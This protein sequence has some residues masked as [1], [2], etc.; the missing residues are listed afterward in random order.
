MKNAIVGLH[1]VGLP[2]RP[3]QWDA[4]RIYWQ[5][6]GMDVWEITVDDPDYDMH[7]VGPRLQ[8]GKRPALMISYFIG[9]GPGHVALELAPQAL[10]LAR[11]IPQEMS[12]THWGHSVTSLFLVTPHTSPVHP[13][14]E[15]VTKDTDFHHD[16]K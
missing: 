3:E 2:S 5:Q 1:H 13:G 10:A 11:E 4:L 16:D 15:L 12:E 8:V 9:T 14:I 6:M 7:G